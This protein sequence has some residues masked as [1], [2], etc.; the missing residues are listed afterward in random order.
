[1]LRLLLRLLGSPCPGGNLSAQGFRVM[2]V[3]GLFS[4][5]HGDRLAE[6]LSVGFDVLADGK[7]GEVG[8]L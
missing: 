5:G 6:C 8:V 4:D 1:M 7:G 3:A 2:V